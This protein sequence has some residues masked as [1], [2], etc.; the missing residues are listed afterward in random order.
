M[1]FRERQQIAICAAAAAIICGFVLLRYMPLRKGMNSLR[2]ARAAEMLA[3]SKASAES[4]QMPAIREQLQQLRAE[5]KNYERQVPAQREL[6]EFLQKITNLMNEHNLR[7]QVIQI[8]EEI[9][10]GELSCIPVSMQ[11]KGRLSQIFEFYRCVQG[12][13]RL[14]RIERVKLV[15]DDDFSGEV[16]M[17]TNAVI[18]YRAEAGQG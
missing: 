10:A 18:Y 1:P 16:I 13:D 12:L 8:D 15:N 9:K 7:G 11:C 14:V 17:Q 4:Q 2:Q 3:I 5:M 6:G